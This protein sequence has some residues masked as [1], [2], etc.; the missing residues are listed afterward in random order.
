MCR[1]PAIYS[2]Y[3]NVFYKLLFKIFYKCAF[4]YF[5]SYDKIVKFAKIWICVKTRLCLKA[6]GIWILNNLPSEKCTT[7]W[8]MLS[9]FYRK[10]DNKYLQVV[11]YFTCFSK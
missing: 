6:Y 5:V 1:N 8:K 11:F 4:S 9:E 3:M 7:L 10:H 2:K